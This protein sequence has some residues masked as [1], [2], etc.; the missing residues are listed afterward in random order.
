M[1]KYQVESRKFDRN[2]DEDSQHHDFDTLEAVRQFL[3]YRSGYGL[4]YVW[5]NGNPLVPFK[6]PTLDELRVMYEKPYHRPWL[7][8]PATHVQVEANRPVGVRSGDS[9]QFIGE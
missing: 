9:V 7:T 6:T 5:V 8:N 1:S 2:G 4:N 3:L